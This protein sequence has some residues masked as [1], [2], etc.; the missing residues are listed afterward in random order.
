MKIFKRTLYFNPY[1]DF[2]II[3]RASEITIRMNKFRPTGEDADYELFEFPNVL[4]LE[5]VI[6][7]EKFRFT[8]ERQLHVVEAFRKSLSWFYDTKLK[9]LFYKSEDG[10]L[11][12]NNDHNNVKTIVYSGTKNHQVMEI[13]PVV[14]EREGQRLE[15]VLVKI[16]QEASFATL[17]ISELMEV[18]SILTNFNFSSE[19]VLMFEMAKALEGIKLVENTF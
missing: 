11:Y 3:S 6:N 7:Q 12:F 13:V 16:N 8:W 18:L 1:N 9:D 2:R 15:G 19:M 4:K 14:V 10:T 17:S 5:I